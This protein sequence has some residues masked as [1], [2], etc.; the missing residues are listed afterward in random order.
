MSG[1]GASAV[2]VNVDSIDELKNK[3]V[4]PT[5]DTFKY[6][7]SANVSGDYTFSSCQGKVLALR[8]NK[9]FVDQVWCN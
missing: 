2:S 7:Y 9:Q 1:P 8:R 6:Q 5:D 4:K 3:G